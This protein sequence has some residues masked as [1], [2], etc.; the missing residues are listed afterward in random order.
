MLMLGGSEAQPA[1]KPHRRHILYIDI[2]IKSAWLVV[3]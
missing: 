1:T 2:G 3:N